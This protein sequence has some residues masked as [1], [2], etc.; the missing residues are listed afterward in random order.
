MALSLK[1]QDFQTKR[2]NMQASID[3]IME[4]ILRGDDGYFTEYLKLESL[5]WNFSLNNKILIH[6]QR[7]QAVRVASIGRFSKL[8][9]LRGHK[10]VKTGRDKY[11]SAV[12]PK[13]GAQAIWIYVPMTYRREE[14]TP[15]GEVKIHQGMT[16]K[17]GMVFDVKDLYFKDDGTDCIDEPEFLPDFCTDLGQD[18]EPYYLALRTWTQGQ[19]IEIEEA[20]LDSAAGASCGGKILEAVNKS[21]GKKFATLIHEVA[22]ELLHQKTKENFSKT[23]AEAEAEA[24]AGVVCSYFGF[25]EQL[26]F[27]AAYLRIHKAT[28]QTV[29][30]SMN[31]ILKTA[32]EVIKGIESEQAAEVA[33]VV[34]ELLEAAAG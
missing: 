10:A 20:Y 5:L 33:E 7:P 31:R 3:S 17:P 1:G 9:V 22:H 29:K 8:A 23:I 13:A 4:S 2:H 14:E 12:A 11:P 34:G 6:L 15:T 28:V 16:F 24:V 32:E 18:T 27:S 25:T 21:V 19:G 26:N 30:D